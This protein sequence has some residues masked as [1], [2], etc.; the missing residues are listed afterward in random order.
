MATLGKALGAAGGCICGSRVLVDYLINRARTF[1]FSTAP[2]PA[3][4][5]AATAGV[6]LVQSNAGEA[7]CRQLWQ[8]VEELRAALRAEPGIVSSAIIPVHIGDEA[9]AVDVAAALRQQGL[10]IPAIRYPTVARGRA[11]LRVTLTA[12]HSA[13]DVARLAAG[14]QV[15]GLSDMGSPS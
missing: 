8:R 12:A 5:A 14:L 7:R 10:F 4:V 9:R 3:A 11:R 15:H 13:A 6:H 2:T 1:I